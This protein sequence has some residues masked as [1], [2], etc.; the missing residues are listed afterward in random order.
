M[1]DNCLPETEAEIRAVIE[2][3]LLLERQQRSRPIDFFAPHPKQLRFIQSQKKERFLIGGNRSG[4]TVCGVYE[5]IQ[6]AR[7]C[8]PTRKLPVPNHGWI[9]SLDSK[10]G[11]RSVQEHVHKL[12]PMDEVREW[13]VADQQVIFKNGSTISFMSCESG[14]EKFQGAMVHYVWFDEEPEPR[15]FRECRMR[16]LDYKGFFWI[17][18][19]PVRGVTWLH[20]YIRQSEELGHGVEMTMSIYDNPAIDGEEIKLIETGAGFSPAEK[21]ARLHGHWVMMSGTCVFSPERLTEAR[22]KVR[23]PIAEGELHYEPPP[24]EPEP[25]EDAD[26]YGIE[27]QEDREAVVDRLQQALWRQVDK[28]GGRYEILQSYERR[29]KVYAWPKPGHHYSIG[30]DPSAGYGAPG[31]PYDVSEDRRRASDPTGVVVWDCVDWQIVAKWVGRIAPEQ[32]ADVLYHLGNWY[33]CA[34]LV[35]ENNTYG[36]AAIRPL[37]D[38]LA[39][40]NMYR[41]QNSDRVFDQ[42]KTVGFNTNSK[43]RGWLISAIQTTLEEGLLDCPSS[44]ILDE[45]ANFRIHDDGKERAASGCRDDLVIAL[46]LALIGAEGMPKIAWDSEGEDKKKKIVKVEEE[47]LDMQVAVTGYYAEH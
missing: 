38:R 36:R 26:P 37:I 24:E 13:R 18:M 22:R 14:W 1:A 46:G 7:G 30:G 16:L 17:T 29:L 44:E 31:N 2:A 15:V 34:L 3:Q 6:L 4:K 12:L 47:V 39:Y 32:L 35:I 42:Q 8:H 19:T 21:E 33:N 40:G 41:Q 9:V 20:D 27:A 43:T 45:L 5:S 25:H 28:G 23:P 11:A 10:Q